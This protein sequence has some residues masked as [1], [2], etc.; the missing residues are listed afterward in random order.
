MAKAKVLNDPVVL[1]QKGPEHEPNL[2]RWVD[3]DAPQFKRYK[4]VGEQSFQSGDRFI[5][6]LFNVNDL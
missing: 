6:G 4:K 2:Q 1:R 5:Q 3:C